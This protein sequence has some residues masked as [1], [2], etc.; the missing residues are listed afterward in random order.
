LIQS[1]LPLLTRRLG[2]LGFATL[3]AS[4]VIVFFWSVAALS[5]LLLSG[6][7]LLQTWPPIDPTTKPNHPLKGFAP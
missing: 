7:S 5:L 4:L 1:L 2:T 3:A 6:L